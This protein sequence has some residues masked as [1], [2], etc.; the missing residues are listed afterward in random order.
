MYGKLMHLFYN[1]KI[2]ELTKYI[3][4]FKF[5]TR[6]LLKRSTKYEHSLITYIDQKPLP[7]FR[8]KYSQR[9][10]IFVLFI[11]IMQ[12]TQI[13]I[14][15]SVMIKFKFSVPWSAVRGDQRPTIL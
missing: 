13:L 14:N 4:Y 11:I 8:K 3:I 12:H 15:I 9:P 7:K 2:R 1:W 5:G 6:Q 10:L